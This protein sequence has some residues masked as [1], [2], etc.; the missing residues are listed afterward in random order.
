MRV[1]EYYRAS[2][3]EDAYQKLQENPKNT[4]LGGGLWIKKISQDHNCLIDLSTLGLN[5]ISE[6]ESEV[7]V[8]ALVTQR[9]F[10]NSPII[11]NLF[12]DALAFSAREIMGVNFRNLATVG[13]SIMGRFPF[14]DLITGLLA[15]HVSLHF[16]PEQVMSL[17][18]FL[19]FKGKM[20]AILVDIRIKKENGKGYF[21]KVKTTAL[22]FAH[23]NFAVSKIND[24]YRIVVGARPMVATLAV[25][26]TEYI[27]AIKEPSEINFI[28]AGEIASDELGFLDNKDSSAEYR[29]DLT[30]VYV[31]RGLMEV[32]K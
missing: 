17:E 23:I 27:N 6:N 14:S 8:G 29:K 28:K 20:N 32:S 30:K 9:D 21:K 22:D 31:K 25:K 2:S 26:A 24:K 13:G 15:Y 19:A 1:N 12:N 7:I 16:Y 10:E 11:R 4:I 18:D 3:L 5:Q